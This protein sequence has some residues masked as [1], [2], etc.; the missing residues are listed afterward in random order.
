MDIEHNI[1][2][3]F[4]RSLY[5]RSS[6][7]SIH[8]SETT[9]LTQRWK[10]SF[11]FVGL[12][13]TFYLIQLSSAH[14]QHDDSTSSTARRFFVISRSLPFTIFV[15]LSTHIARVSSYTAASNYC[16]ASGTK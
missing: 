16:I 4:V 1:W 11:D 13:Q 12:I 10:K 8:S 7:Y 15:C 2:S 6:S 3:L 5:E 9:K 14:E